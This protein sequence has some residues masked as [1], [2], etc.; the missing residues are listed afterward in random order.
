MTSASPRNQMSEDRCPPSQPSTQVHVAVG[1]LVGCVYKAGTSQS[2]GLGVVVVIRI[3]V[4]GT[5]CNTSEKPDNVFPLLLR[6]ESWSTNS[7]EYCTPSDKLP[8]SGRSVYLA[9]RRS[10]C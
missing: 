10:L 4:E 6:I 2:G 3:P 1:W 9:Q 5:W 7:V 8:T